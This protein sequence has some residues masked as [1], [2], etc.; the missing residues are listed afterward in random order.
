MFVSFILFIKKLMK[1]KTN[2]IHESWNYKIYMTFRCLDK[3]KYC[4]LIWDLLIKKH[5]CVIVAFKTTTYTIMLLFFYLILWVVVCCVSLSFHV[6]S[7]FIYIRQ[8]IIHMYFHFHKYKT[9]LKKYTQHV[10]TQQTQNKH[11]TKLITTAPRQQTTNTPKQT[12]TTNN[13]NH[14]WAAYP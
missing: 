1:V 9:K 3:R 7:T 8:I 4:T 12:Q 11:T 5:V 2:T 6:L 14:W 10:Q 13:N